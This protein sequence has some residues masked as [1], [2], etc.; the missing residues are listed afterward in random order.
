MHPLIHPSYHSSHPPRPPYE[1]QQTDPARIKAKQTI[2]PMCQYNGIFYTECSHVRFRLHRFC[3]ALFNE[4]RR[5]NNPAQR[6]AHP[7][8]FNP[9]LPGCEPFALFLVNGL[10][11]ETGGPGTGNVLWWTFVLSEWC[12]DCEMLVSRG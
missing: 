9:D 10:P 12:P 5:I 1:D 2:S 11:D 8:P 6:E 4:L 3:R 7:L